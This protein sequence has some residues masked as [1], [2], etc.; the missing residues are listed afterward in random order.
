MPSPSRL[1]TGSPHDKRDA[2]SKSRDT[3][4]VVELRA[5]MQGDGPLVDV[6]IRNISSRGMMLEAPDPPRVGAYVELFGTVTAVGR[7]VWK[8]EDSFGIS[9]RDRVN[10]PVVLGKPEMKARR[11]TPKLVAAPRESRIE[12]ADESRMLGR[13]ID[14]TL[15]AIAVMALSGL[16]ALIAY[17]VLS[18]P[19]ET[20]VHMLK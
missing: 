16:F 6:R 3:R 7:V 15:I 13:A 9:T 18:R 20:L 4:H 2:V 12:A 14:F 10:L 11:A 8:D 1:W 5:R 19:L 17:S